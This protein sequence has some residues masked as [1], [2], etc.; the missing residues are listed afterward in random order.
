MLSLHLV[1][2]AAVWTPSSVFWRICLLGEC[3]VAGDVCF[4][5]LL[6]TGYMCEGF[7]FFSKNTEEFI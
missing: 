2:E 7:L 4:Q 1:E 5:F 3:T 6:V